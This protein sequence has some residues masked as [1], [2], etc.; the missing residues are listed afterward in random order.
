VL[1]TDRVS[2]EYD[3]DLADEIRDKA[4]KLGAE[5][6]VALYEAYGADENTVADALG[7][8]NNDAIVL[9]K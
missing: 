9:I 4:Q 3:A 8:K 6:I 5:V 7:D 1:I 2:G